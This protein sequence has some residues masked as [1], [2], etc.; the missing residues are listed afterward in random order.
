MGSVPAQIL[1]NPQGG[2]NEQDQSLSQLLFRHWLAVIYCLVGILVVGG[3]WFEDSASNHLGWKLIGL[4]A[5]LHLI[6][7]LVRDWIG[8]LVGTR[9][10]VISV[11]S[12]G[13]A[14]LTIFGGYVLWQRYFG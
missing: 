11:T 5:I 13:V 2:N 6:W 14:L 7:R 4:T 8:G 10:F 3:W 12:M 9:N 1:N